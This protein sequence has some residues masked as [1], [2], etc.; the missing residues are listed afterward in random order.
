MGAAA[1]PRAVAPA[2]P[3]RAAGRAAAHGERVALA[4]TAVAVALLPLLVPAGPANIAP[5]DVPI[6]VA[7]LACLL[8]AGISGHRWRFPY[9]LPVG[10]LLAGGAIGAIVGPVPRAGIIALVQDLV[11]IAWCWAVVNLCSRARNLRILLATWVYS[12]IVWASLVFVGLATGSTFLTGQIE[13][14]GTRVQ[15]TLADPSY[16]ANYLLMS[17]MLVWA[18]GRPR[19]PAA[20]FAASVLLL[21]AMVPTGSNSGMLSLLVGTTVAVVMSVHRRHGYAPAA[22]VLAVL[23]LGGYGAVSGIDLTELQ[24]RAHGSRHAFLRDGIGRGTSVN[25]RSMLMGESLELYRS[26]S[27]LGEGPVSTKPRLRAEQAPFIKEAHDDYLA[28]L[29]ERGLIGL[30]GVT[31]LVVALSRHALR[32]ARPGLSREFAATVVRPH[33]LVGALAATMVVSVVYEIF[34]VRHVWTLFAILA[35]LSI[36]GRR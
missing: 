19:R 33:A 35:A 34:H 17:F 24:E 14:Q 11:L 15:L 25:Q 27:P 1:V 26:G 6:A 20:R 16:A 36:W 12:S 9:V 28:A 21:A 5:V 2:L 32:A 10:L 22:A 7:L 30:V 18:T 13:R 4:T 31:V 29:I 23:A 8:W 3:A